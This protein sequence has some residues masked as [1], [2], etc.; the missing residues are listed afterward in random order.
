[1]LGGKAWITWD[2]TIESPTAL[3]RGKKELKRK[4]NGGS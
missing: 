3:K 2:G 4:F 1:M